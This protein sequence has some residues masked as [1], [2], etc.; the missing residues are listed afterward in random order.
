MEINDALLDACKKRLLEKVQR[1]L[2]NGADPNMEGA[3]ETAVYGRPE[4]VHALLS[5]GAN[6]NMTTGAGKTI[7]MAAISGFFSVQP[8]FEYGG[9]WVMR[10][11][12]RT[13]EQ[14]KIV[15]SLL[16]AGADPNASTEKGMTALI[17]AVHPSHWMDIHSSCTLAD[18]L[19]YDNIQ[20][21]KLL[22]SAGADASTENGKAALI[23]AAREGH[24]EVVRVLLDAGADPNAAN[25]DKTP[26][27]MAVSGKTTLMMAAEAGHAE[28]VR[29]L[30]S[31]GADPNAVDKEWNTA[32]DIAKANN[33][34]EIVR[35]L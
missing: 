23:M 17:M 10:K 34:S 18:D 3:L 16:D 26:V 8:P 6:P 21:V 20:F 22:L 31:A 1:C 11:M 12:V 19:N 25:S 4:I 9:P 28:V 14:P 32:L 29:V 7:L 5:A 13:G 2:S 30:L 27:R 24:A 35:I 33:H 15:K